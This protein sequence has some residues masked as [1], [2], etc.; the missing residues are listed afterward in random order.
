M[1]LIGD[2][3]D[4]RGAGVMVVGPAEGAVG[5]VWIGS[6]VA[7]AMG[8]VDTGAVVWAGIEALGAGRFRGD[9]ATGDAVST[10][11]VGTEVS[12]GAA[13]TCTVVSAGVEEV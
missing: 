10:E 2:R 9:T 13:D 12:M 5:E 7:A 11:V 3:A 8:D 4:H 1:G 6:V